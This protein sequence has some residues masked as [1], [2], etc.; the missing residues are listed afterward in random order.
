M[1]SEIHGRDPLVTGPVRAADQ[2]EETTLLVVVDLVDGEPDRAAF[3]PELARVLDSLDDAGGDLTNVG[4][5][6][7]GSTGGT[8]R[9]FFWGRRENI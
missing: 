9:T 2:P 8:I 6:E 5:V 3:V 4:R 7:G 1:V